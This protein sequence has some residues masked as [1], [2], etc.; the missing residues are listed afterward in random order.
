MPRAE[1]ADSSKEA[2]EFD[3][4]TYVPDADVHDFDVYE[5]GTSYAAEG[6]T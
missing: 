2:M 5:L 3:N 6:R 1:Q 4:W